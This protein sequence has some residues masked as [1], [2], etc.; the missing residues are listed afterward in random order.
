[1]VLLDA[2]GW[3]WGITIVLLLAGGFFF[4]DKL[5]RKGVYEEGTE[6]RSRLNSALSEMQSL[7]DPGH[8][9]VMEER[10]RKRGEQDNASDDPD[11]SP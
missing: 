3:A 10:E 11:L 9:H 5:M 7:V 2:G 1:M 4:L 6:G 8:R